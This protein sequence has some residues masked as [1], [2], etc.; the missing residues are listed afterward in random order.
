MAV[1]PAMPVPAL[2]ATGATVKAKTVTTQA[3]ANGSIPGTIMTG[4]VAR[5]H[6]DQ[7]L[8]EQLNEETKQKYVKGITIVIPPLQ[9]LSRQRYN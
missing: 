1:S 8:A 9:R 4:K 5:Q 7:E 2:N 3:P 6:G